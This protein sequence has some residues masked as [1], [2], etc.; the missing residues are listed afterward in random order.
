M[1]VTYEPIATQ[2]LGSAQASVTFSSIPATYTDLVLVT[3]ANTVS[4]AENYAYVYFNSDTGA[5]YSRTL[6]TGNGSAASSARFSN[7]IPIT[8]QPTAKSN[9]IL[10]V[11]NYANSTTFKTA[12]WRDNQTAAILSA[13]VG[14]WRNTAAI[15]TIA[16]T[17]F[18]ANI[19]TGSTFTLYGIKAE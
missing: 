10:Q 17:G 8:L 3:N 9:N 13:G 15:T 4:G 7:L 18:T 16:V 12:I 2:T 5:N 11:M 6:L 1:T 14:L 19:Q